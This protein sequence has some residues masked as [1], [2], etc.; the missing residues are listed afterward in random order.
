MTRRRAPRPAAE[1]L[2]TA[3][4]QAAP[5]TRLAAAQAA[6]TASVGDR[7]AAVASPVAERSGSLIVGCVD[8]VWAE[9]LDLMRP[10]LLERLRDRLGEEAPRDLRIR[11]EGGAD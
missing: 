2:R 11:V 1:A 6:W 7:I 10:R 8:P 5:K 4:E 3:L 9:E